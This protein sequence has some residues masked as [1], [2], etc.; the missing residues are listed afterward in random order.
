MS[1]GK[2]WARASR[3]LAAIS[4]VGML[5]LAGAGGSG[6]RA[7]DPGSTT[8][9]AAGSSTVPAPGAAD[10][11]AAAPAAALLQPTIP[12]TDKTVDIGFYMVSGGSLDLPSTSIVLDFYMWLNWLGPKEPSFEFMNCKQ[13]TIINKTLKCPYPGSNVSHCVYRIQ[14]VFE[15]VLDLADYPFS[16]FVIKIVF[17][18]TE[19]KL[20]E[21]TYLHNNSKT[22]FDPAFRITG[23]DI[24]RFDLT[25]TVHTYDCN[26]GSPLLSEKVMKDPYSQ[27]TLSMHITRNKFLIFVKVVLPALLFVLVALLGGPLP[28]EQ[29]SQKISLSVASLF[30]SVAYHLSLSQTV[31]PLGYLTFIDKMMLGHYSLT[32]IHLVLLIIAFLAHK[33]GNAERE[34]R[35][36]LVHKILV[37]TLLG[38]LYLGLYLSLHA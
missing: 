27:V 5:V 36:R 13:F 29:I 26:F 19:Y 30:S 32:F 37:P 23:W 20:D 22:G 4:L 1:G 17:E 35:V 12:L 28:S 24:A 3:A 21:R 8:V 31:P 34:A 2:R 25:S 15:Q 10:G 18:D 7:Q 16:D 38:L 6:L 33:E 14:G 11:A 9:P